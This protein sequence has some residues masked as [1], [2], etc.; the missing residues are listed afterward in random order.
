MAGSRLDITAESTHVERNGQNAA[1]W[2][3]RKPVN[4]VADFPGSGTF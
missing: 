2:V 1:Q 4:S 3:S